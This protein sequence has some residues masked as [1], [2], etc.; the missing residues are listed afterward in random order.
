M[1][2]PLGPKKTQIQLQLLALC[3]LGR[4]HH[5]SVKVLQEQCQNVSKGFFFHFIFLFFRLLV[6]N[7]DDVR[8]GWGDIRAGWG[9]V[10]AGW[11]D[12]RAGIR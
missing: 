5:F 11:G 2:W 1:I 7:D 8:A 12:V 3:S 6:K 4:R 10:R 9:D